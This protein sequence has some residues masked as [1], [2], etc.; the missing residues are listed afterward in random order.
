[1]NRPKEK[2]GAI[3]FDCD[4]TLSS[5]EGIDELAARAGCESQIAPLTT[6]AMNGE[7]A[8]ED[9]YA[10][11]LDIVRP[12]RAALD[13]LAKRYIATIVEGAKETIAALKRAAKPVFVVSGGLLQP[14]A[15]LSEDLG[16]SADRVRAVAVKL[17]Q[18]GAYH[19]FD[20]S[21]PLHRSRGKALICAEIASQFGRVALIGDGKTDVEARETGT[22]V[23][24]FGGVVCRQAVIDSADVFVNGPALTGVLQH[25][26]TDEEWNTRT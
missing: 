13:W 3:C 16:I 9:V 6:A 19:G 5:I 17:D 10:K 25:L 12:D 7:L 2:F 14:V 15:A 4:S 26:L 21:S 23:V 1:M 20:T 11:R 8:I 22:Y 24:G 18:N